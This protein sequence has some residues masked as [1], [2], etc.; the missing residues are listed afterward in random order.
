MTDIDWS[1]APEG[2]THYLPAK[3]DSCNPFWLKMSDPAVVSIGYP[4]SREWYHTYSPENQ[5]EIDFYRLI[6]RPV[7]TWTGT[8][9]PPVGAAVEAKCTAKTKARDWFPAEVKY[10]SPY[11]VVLVDYSTD[12][13]DGEFVA[14]P[15]TLI[16]QPRRTPE[17]IAEQIAAEEREAAIDAMK[18]LSPL[19]D[20]G[21][22]R[23]VCAALYDAGYRKPEGTNDE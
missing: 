13:L 11:T 8:G 6:K 18:A 4:G 20:K 10:I 22:S 2:A 7:L 17:Q 23:R 1:K 16:I 12:E 19:L 14:H 5:P 9:L 3:N 21:W 15:A